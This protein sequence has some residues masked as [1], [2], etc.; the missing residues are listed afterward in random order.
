MLTNCSD[1]RSF[2]Y[3]GMIYNYIDK[4][5]AAKVWMTGISPINPN[6]AILFVCMC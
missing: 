6:D 1:L 4:T 3:A 5:G 2:S